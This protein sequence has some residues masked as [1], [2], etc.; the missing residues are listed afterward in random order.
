[1]A[2]TDVK[3]PE[4]N[5]NANDTWRMR[6]ETLDRFVQAGRKVIIRNRAEARLR[7]IRS[8]MATIGDKSCLLYTSP[9]PRD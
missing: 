4:Y 8:L 3:E 5:E 7:G 9:S 2:L 6:R 1:M